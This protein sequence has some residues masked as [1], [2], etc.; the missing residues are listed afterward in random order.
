MLIKGS[1]RHVLAA[2]ARRLSEKL[3]AAFLLWSWLRK[4]E[5][6]CSTKT[7]MRKEM[8]DFQLLHHPFIMHGQFMKSRVN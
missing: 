6:P 4:V 3:D 7:A 1:N 8:N 2:A 5:R